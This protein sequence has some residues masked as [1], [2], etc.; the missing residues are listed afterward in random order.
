MRK[1]NMGL[2]RVVGLVISVVILL[3][4][5]IALMNVFDLFGKDNE[6]RQS[7]AVMGAIYPGI[8]GECFA[9]RECVDEEGTFPKGEGG[10]YWQHLGK[11]GCPMADDV[12]KAT[13]EFKYC[14]ALVAP[15]TFF[16]SGAVLKCDR[17]DPDYEV[18]HNI[19]SDDEGEWFTSDG[20][21]CYQCTFSGGMCEKTDVDKSN[22]EG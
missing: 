11:F 7:C 21:T 4:V 17:N 8:K 10:G 9:F 5:I 3:V 19:P 20:S 2:E 1:G 14:C 18:C 12:E 6:E 22:C 15:G 13:E 16:G